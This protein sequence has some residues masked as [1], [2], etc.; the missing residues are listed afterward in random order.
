MFQNDHFFYYFLTKT[1]DVV[2]QKN[3][4]NDFFSLLSTQS[5]MFTNGKENNASIHRDMF[6]YLNLC[7]LFLKIHSSS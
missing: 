2:T 3:C 1:F 7:D 5:I 6:V 4:H